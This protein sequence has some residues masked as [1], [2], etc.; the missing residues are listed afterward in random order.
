MAK[1]KKPLVAE[2]PEWFTKIEAYTNKASHVEA[3]I[4]EL[5]EVLEL[6]DI[7]GVLYEKD[8]PDII[9][10]CVNSNVFKR[11][12]IRGV[13]KNLIVM[14]H[15]DLTSEGHPI[16]YLVRSVQGRKLSIGQTYV[17]SSDFDDVLVFLN[18]KLPLP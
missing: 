5:R 4:L 9:T 14:F 13:L 2:A 1:P 10:V 3:L 18:Q 11:V 7:Q 17:S 16:K 15:V 12:P 8:M 6:E